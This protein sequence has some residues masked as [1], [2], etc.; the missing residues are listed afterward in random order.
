MKLEEKRKKEKKEEYDEYELK[1]L[2]TKIN[3]SCIVKKG[4]KM[5]KDSFSPKKTSYWPVAIVLVYLIINIR[6]EA[7]FATLFERIVD[8]SVALSLFL[9]MLYTG[10]KFFNLI[11]SRKSFVGLVACCQSGNG[12]E[13][14]KG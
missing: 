5:V 1:E 8:G 6:V 11:E 9:L 13:G 10:A 2:L 12:C 4:E 3:K 14:K 7:G